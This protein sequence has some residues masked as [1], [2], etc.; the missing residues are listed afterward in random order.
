[1]K[2][3]QSRYDRL[4]ANIRDE[5]LAQYPE[6][7][8]WADWL[9]PNHVLV[10]TRFA[11]E[12]AQKYGANEELAKAAA[13]LHDCADF[14]MSRFAEGHDSESISLARGILQDSGYNETEIAVVVDDAIRLHSCYG[15][16]RPTTLEGKVLATADA[17]A[18]FKTD[19][20][21]HA[22]WSFGKDRTLESLQSWALKKI[23]RDRDAKIHFEDERA[24]VANDHAVLRVLLGGQDK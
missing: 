16:D 10:V 22:A 9:W 6:R 20:Y 12:L 17:L 1:M 8:Q 3:T 19:F 4:F 13:L 23:D 18:H 15:D 14:K 5:Y 24:A 7:E 21:I 2:D 11:G